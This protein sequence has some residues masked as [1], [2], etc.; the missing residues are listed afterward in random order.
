M[1]TL[2]EAI[3]IAKNRNSKVDTYQEYED[4]YSFYIDDGVIRIGGG[5]CAFY[6]RKSDGKVLRCYEYDLPD[7]EYEH[8][9]VEI[10]EPVKINK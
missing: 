7:P 9:C 1:I 5:D 2:S 4:V 8:T 10:G 3:A 6:V